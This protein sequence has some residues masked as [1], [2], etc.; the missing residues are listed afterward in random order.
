MGYRLSDDEVARFQTRLKGTE[1]VG[2]ALDIWFTTTH[3]FLEDILPPCFTV[4]EEPTGV[5]QFVHA[6]GASLDFNSVTIYVAVQFGEIHGYYDLTMLLTG[7]MTITFGRELWGESKK[8][9]NIE[10]DHELPDVSAFAER[11]G[12]T[13]IKATGSFGEDLGPRE[14]KDTNLHLKA[15]VNVGGTD[16]EYDPIMFVLTGT[17][18]FETYHEGTGTLELA[19]TSADPCGSIP[20]VSVDRYSFGRITATY[21]QTQYPIEG[22]EGY[23][24]YVI[25]RS[26]DLAG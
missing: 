1:Y 15:F 12:T 26:Y 8:R 17:T 3:A 10:F 24:P 14:V 23:L 2:E 6:A 19:S 13:L 25:G 5:V 18:R 16:L 21:T 7:D 20:I 22:R 11:N 4:P 9:A